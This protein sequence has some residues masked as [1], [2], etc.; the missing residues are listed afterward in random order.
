[1]S[2]N[3]RLT[4]YTNISLITNIAQSGLL[5]HTST[6]TYNNNFQVTS[7]TYAGQREAYT[8]D[9][10]GLLITS[11]AYTLTR[12]LQNAYTTKLTDGS[13]TQNRSYNNFGEITEVSDNTF[14]YELSQRDNAGAIVQKSETLNGVTE[15]FDYTFDN[16]GRLTQ[17]NKNNT[18]TET[19]TYDNNGNRATATVNGKIISASYTLDDNLFSY[20]DIDYKY[21]EDGYLSE[22]VTPQDTTT[23]NYGTMGE[24]LSVQTPNKNISYKHNAN[25]QR[26]AKLIDGQITEKYLWANLTT[27]LAIYDKDDTLITGQALNMHF[28]ML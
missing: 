26:V 12:D 18:D 3:P 22:K 20:G 16:M 24:L 14:A 23:Y 2:I 21:D 4:E 9:N 10:D 8:Y 28:F 15:T 27:L 6:F 19:Y 17:V 5:N 13:F 7:S 1:M 25:K 11:G